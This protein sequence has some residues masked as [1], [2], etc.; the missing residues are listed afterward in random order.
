MAKERI[1]ICYELEDIAEAKSFLTSCTLIAADVETLPDAGLLTVVGYTG[2]DDS[3][4]IRTYVFPLY[5]GRSP[6][7]GTHIYI[8]QVFAALAAINA[9]PARFTF[10][11]GPYDLFWFIRYGIPVGNYA[12]DSM[13]MW[14]S[15]FPELPK[16]LAF[17]SSV[18]QDDF[19]YWKSGRKSDSYEDYL[20]YNGRDCYRTLW[21]TIHLIRL[22]QKDK[23]ALKN[24]SDAHLRTV[25]F[26]SVS[27]KG[28]KV[29]EEKRAEHKITLEA[30][31]AKRLEEIR[32]L[33]A[34]PEF[35]PQSPQQ[36]SELFYKILGAQKR[37]AKGRTVNR[38]EDASTGKIPMR[39]IIADGNPIIRRIVKAIMDGQEPAKQI[40]NVINMRQSRWGRIYTSYGATSTTTTRLNS[41]EAPIRVGG[42]LQNWRKNYR[43]I[44]TA[45]N[46]DCFFLD[47]DLSASDDVFV[48]FESG[49]PKKIT[50]FRSGK[51]THCE[52][53]T[54]FFPDWTYE[55]V[56][57]GKRAKDPRV[58]HPI[59]G[60][61]QITKKL[62]HGCNYLMAA[63]TLLM[64][65]GREAIVAAAKEVGYADAG[66]WIQLALVDF[67][68]SRENL[69][70]NHYTRFARSGDGSWYS[71][72]RKELEK[73]GGFTTAFGYFQ[74]FLGDSSD[75]KVLRAVAASA[76]Q[77]N[78]AGR[79]NA[80][81]EELEFG[82]IKPFFRDA[83][84]PSYGVEPLRVNERDFGLSL[85]LQSH[86]SLTWNVDTRNPGWKEGV[87]RVLKVMNRPTI[88]KNKLTGQLE[89]F[90]VGTEVEVGY[91]WGPAMK[92]VK[93][94]I[95]AI[96]EALAT[97]RK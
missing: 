72:L 85:R 12:Y 20:L 25:I 67:C 65:A 58:I 94:T 19:I 88:I 3:G 31:A 44:I 97:L 93:G 16:T 71:E 37:D 14:W 24:W 2:L 83:E 13:S 66:L 53:T 92:E 1:R 56:L 51:D 26:L 41:T 50:L 22:L 60:I 36:K 69:Y 74:R 84:N 21:N 6:S 40:S 15:L 59:T 73:T 76:G 61:R 90:S 32:Y 75:D 57:A 35:N 33:V 18:L 34:D 95:P 30:D 17:V 64:T 77:A 89:E 46:D 52:N 7:A 28:V 29:D 86:D 70:R 27:L 96:E 10:H 39:A 11:N 80:V 55:Q 87:E 48:S 45:D 5:Y 47:I 78:T 23:R 79:I 63:L 4:R 9:C 8:E 68:E 91:S 54:L 82:I 42:N 62:S 49:D 38:I 81:V 43:D